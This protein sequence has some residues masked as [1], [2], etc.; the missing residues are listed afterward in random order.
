MLKKRIICDLTNSLPSFIVN[1]YKTQKKRTGNFQEVR[2]EGAKEYVSRVANAVRNSP[3]LQALG[4]DIPELLAA[5]LQATAILNRY[6]P[7]RNSSSSS[8]CQSFPHGYR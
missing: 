5:Q 7:N 8:F 2:V 6:L 1:Y 4:P 3:E